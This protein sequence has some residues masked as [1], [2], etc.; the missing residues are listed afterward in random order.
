MAC[1]TAI[2]P[3]PSDFPVV[4]AEL[5]VWDLSRLPKYFLSNRSSCTT[6]KAAITLGQSNG[7]VSHIDW[8]LM[9]D[10][11]SSYIPWAVRCVPSDLH[12][13]FLEAFSTATVA[14]SLKHEV[15]SELASNVYKVRVYSLSER[16]ALSSLTHFPALH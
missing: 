4:A 8:K 10:P 2:N 11:S 7:K 3:L 12:T 13:K 14:E 5:S 16:I 15:G 1:L 6:I 9:E